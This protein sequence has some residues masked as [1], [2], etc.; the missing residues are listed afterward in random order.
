MLSSLVSQPR[1]VEIIISHDNISASMK[2]HNQKCIYYISSTLY[3]TKMY[4]KEIGNRFS[5]F[6]IKH[7]YNVK[8]NIFYYSI[9]LFQH[10]FLVESNKNINKKGLN[11]FQSL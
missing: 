10:E 3:I 6:I 1:S 11:T 5:K 7:S 8:L 9:A 4:L 2:I